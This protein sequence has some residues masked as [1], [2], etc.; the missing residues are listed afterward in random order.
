VHGR[1]VQPGQHDD[2]VRDHGIP[3][4]SSLALLY[5]TDQASEAVATNITVTAT[6]CP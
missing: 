5:A 4:G 3:A 1:D 6:S 2:H